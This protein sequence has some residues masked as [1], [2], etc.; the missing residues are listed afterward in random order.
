MKQHSKKE[1]LE[2]EK[3]RNVQLLAAHYQRVEELPLGAERDRVIRE[4]L[5]CRNA[6]FSINTQL[7]ELEEG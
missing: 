6:I 7:R 1:Q 5:R 2:K 4:I 3:M